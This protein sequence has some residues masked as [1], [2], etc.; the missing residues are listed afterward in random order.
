MSARTPRAPA[1][2]EFSWGPLGSLVSVKRMRL[3]HV[4]ALALVLSL[5][6]ACATATPPRADFGDIPVPDG[7]AYQPDRS[8]SLQSLHVRAARHIYRGRFEPDSLAAVIRTTLE[9][10]GWTQVSGTST[11]SQGS[12]QVYQKGNDSLQVRVWEGGLFNWYTYVE[13]TAARITQG[14]LSVA[15]R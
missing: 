4:A 2:Y 8:A 6:T 7:L 12:T 5:A 1:R 9:G 14:S 3:H 10:N 11:P 15:T 13:Y